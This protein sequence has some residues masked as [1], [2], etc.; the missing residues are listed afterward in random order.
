[1]PPQSRFDN[2]QNLR[3]A[4]LDTAF[5][6][7]FGTL[8]GGSFIVKFIQYLG[9]GDHEIGLVTGLP[10]LLGV[11]QIVGASWGR[12]YNGYKTFA[13]TGGALWRLLYVPIALLPL[14]ALSKQVSL[15]VIVAC[16]TIAAGCVLTVAPIY[17]DWLA[18]MVPERSR[19]WYFSRRNALLTAV[20]SVISLIGAFVFDQFEHRGQPSTGFAIVFGAGIL[21]AAIS[22]FFYVR[23]K[24]IPRENPV[25]EP[26]V[27]GMRR[28]IKP[29]HDRDFR[30]VLIFLTIFFFGQTI[31]GNLWGAFALESLKLDLTF[32]SLFGVC[33]A[34]GMIL[35]SKLWG[36]LNDRYGAR[37]SLLIAGLM[38]AL[39]PLPWVVSFPSNP[40]AAKVTLLVGHLIMGIGWSGV[41]LSQFNLLLATSKE[42]DRANY[43]A[44]GL[45]LQ[46]I[47]SGF[48][49][50]AGA[51]L[52]GALRTHMAPELAYKVVFVT[53]SVLRASSLFLL[54][55]VREPGSKQ[56]G[57]ALGHLRTVTPKGVRALR[58][59]ERSVDPE[60]R[61][62]AIES[63]ADTGYAFAGGELAKALNDPSAKVRR[64]AAAALVKLGDKDA[65]RTLRYQLEHYPDHAEEETVR[66]LGALGDE[67]AA[68]LLASFLH[69][70]RAQIRRAAAH[71][72]ADVGGPEA[73]NALTESA[74]TEDDPD[75][76]RA[77]IQGLRQLESR[78]AEEPISKALLDKHPSV[79]IAAA[80]AVA[81]ME[82]VT[83]LPYL[84]ESLAKFDDEAESE[85]AY[86]LGVVGGTEDIHL[87]LDSSEKV[88]SR[89]GRRRCLLGVSR[90]L[91]VEPEVYRLMMLDDMA[92]DAKLLSALTSVVRKSPKARVAVQ[93]YAQGDEAGALHA[94][95]LAFPQH[96]G[97]AILAERKPVEGYLIAASLL[98]KS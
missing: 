52:M 64:Q 45:T 98:S 57:S 12:R 84:R 23:M 85:V 88:K 11:L 17:S 61:A 79:R 82:L 40:V 67:S 70:P 72:L 7:S 27:A 42:E 69:S 48:A 25:R 36:Q 75:L 31:G 89:I 3:L 13:G 81:E 60:V 46:S 6:T 18:E 90:I 74:L 59:L 20:A 76:R 54:I 63:M 95:H 80:E 2:L 41:A 32:L 78:D 34:T 30:P 49:P 4:N 56:L 15:F 5:A 51:W 83:A 68:S 33:H 66:A 53:A 93:R 71:A 28:I 92:K 19:G 38:F 9:G 58:S 8:I 35:S 87:I 14:V 10:S 96:E 1:M 77:S 39:N 44:A 97:L 43:I 29:F 16:V 26:I 21:C 94:L 22:M 37:P 50:L 47:V 65:V 73:I 86:A 55:K 62:E 91:G 24:D